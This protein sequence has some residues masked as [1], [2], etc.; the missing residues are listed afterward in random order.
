MD[1]ISSSGKRFLGQLGLIAH[2]LRLLRMGVFLQIAR[3]V[4]DFILLKLKKF[5]LKAHIGGHVIWG[6]FRHRSFLDDISTGTYEPLMV[7]LFKKHLHPGM[8]VIDGGAHVGF[9]TLLAAQLVGPNGRVF[10]FEPDPYNFRCLVFNVGKNRY[11]NVTVVQKAIA[12]RIGNTI[13]YQSSGT[14]SSSLGKRKENEN[15]FQGMSVEKVEVPSTTLDAELDGAPVNVIKLDI[16]GAETLALQGMN[17]II[18]RD[19]PLVLF[20]EINPSALR[21][22]GTSPEILI[23][24][25]KNLAFDI[26]FIDESSQEL[27][28]LTGEPLIRKGN[29][30]CKRGQ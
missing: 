11:E 26:Y 24:T 30:Y 8:T 16:E 19:H 1:A 5:P 20:V 17:E 6:C 22:L 21:S 15:F 25:L 2:L 28:P 23:R 3:D 12:D 18:H 29:L 13:F 10:S 27:L 14:I 7:D 9:Y 4:V